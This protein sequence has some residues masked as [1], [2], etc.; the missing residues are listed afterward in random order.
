MLKLIDTSILFPY[1]GSVVPDLLKDS[2]SCTYVGKS[3]V[4]DYFIMRTNTIKKL[5]FSLN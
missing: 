2:K 4:A 5:I 3:L 1:S